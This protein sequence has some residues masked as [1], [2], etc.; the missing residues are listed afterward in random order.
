[1]DLFAVSTREIDLHGTLAHVCGEDL[2][3][4][5]RLLA[6]TPLAAAVLGG[7][8][9]LDDLVG[10]GLRPLAERKAHGKIGVDGA[11]SA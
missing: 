4:A 7:V 8:I 6:S 3:E 9:S 11:G 5:V 1:V 10:S 2:G